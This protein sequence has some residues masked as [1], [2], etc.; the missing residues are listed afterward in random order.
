MNSA[1]TTLAAILKSLRV[2]KRSNIIVES[3]FL[4][5][6][7]NVT[8]LCSIQKYDT[9]PRSSVI[10]VDWHCQ[11]WYEAIEHSKMVPSAPISNLH[12]PPLSYFGLW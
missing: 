2:R 7:Y 3:E 9:V 6:L 10:E 12:Y 5:M 8:G 1:T 11:L 4:D